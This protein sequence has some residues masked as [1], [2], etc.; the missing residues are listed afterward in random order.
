[1]IRLASCLWLWFQCV[2]PLIPSRN[3]YHLTCVSL[4]LDMGYLFTAAP[5]K[6]SHC[7]LPWSWG[8]SSWLCSC[9]VTATAFPRC[10]SQVAQWW[11]IWVSMQETQVRPLGQEDSLE[12]GM[13]THS[14][15]LAWKIPWPEDL[16]DYSARDCKELHMSSLDT[17]R[18]DGYLKE[19]PSWSTGLC[20]TLALSKDGNSTLFI[21][22]KTQQSWKNVTPISTLYCRVS[23]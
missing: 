11:R 21:N 6:R 12:K 22:N 18:K 14:S 4:T 1:M 20:I 19:Q 16:A 10:G 3:T 2:C 9:I 17:Q 23:K 15:I 13:A 7:S 5:A 8:S